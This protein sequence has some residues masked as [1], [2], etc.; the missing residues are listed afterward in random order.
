MTGKGLTDEAARA[1]T[2]GTRC[3]ALRA[4]RLS[5]LVTRLFEEALRGQGITVAQ[6][7]L[8]GAAILEGP[9]QPARLARMLDLEKSTLSRNL[10]LLEA[11]GLVRI[12]SSD[13]GGQRVTVTERGRRALVEA[14][15]AWREAQARAI[16]ALGD[17]VVGR[18][19]TM[20]AALGDDRRP[21]RTGRGGGLQARASEARSTG[22]AKR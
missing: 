3:I 1:A 18:L 9:L 21:H 22:V 13:E 5:R 16:A 11:E 2:E 4:R 12:G 15:P 7:T 20:I 8:L 6:F 14:L 17:V 19:D 10:R